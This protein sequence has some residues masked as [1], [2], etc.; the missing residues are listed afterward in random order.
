MIKGFIAYL[1][2]R[3]LYFLSFL[4]SMIPLWFPILLIFYR[5][6]DLLLGITTFFMIICSKIYLETEITGGN[7]FSNLLYTISRMVV[8]ISLQ[9]VII[10]LMILLLIS[11]TF[12]DTKFVS[13]IF[14]LILI[15]IISLFLFGS[16][17]YLERVWGYRGLK[18]DSMGVI[19]K[20]FYQLIWL[21]IMF[22]NDYTVISLGL[23]L[24]LYFHTKD[25]MKRFSSVF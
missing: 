10:F 22:S 16:D 5:D 7:P 4:I 21:I 9:L 17:R 12:G 18:G 15:V 6:F 24:S 19:T 13:V 11:L 23:L 14:F 20:I 3:P 8:S 25:F 2:E 1:L